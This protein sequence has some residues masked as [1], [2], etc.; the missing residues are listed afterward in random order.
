M[1]PGLFHTLLSAALLL[2]AAASAADTRTLTPRQRTGAIDVDG[3]LDEADW[4]QAPVG[5]DF[6]QTQPDE[7]KP[8]TVATRVRVL[9]DETSLY[10]G[11]ECDD[12]EEPTLLLNRRDRAVEADSISI[13][14]DS[15]LDK[16]T[17]Y[18]F[19][20]Y[21]S[22][23]QLDGL[24]FDDTGFGTEWDAAWESAVARTK[25]GWSVEM[26]IPLRALR[27][28]EKVSAMGLDV[29]RVLARRH[30][31]SHWQFVPRG[32]P[33]VV[34]R[35]GSLTGLDGMSPVRV[36]ELKPY[37]AA[38]AVLSGPKDG[39]ASAPGR[40]GG[41]SSI[42]LNTS[43]TGQTCAG[44]DFRVGL[45]SDLALLG[46]VNPDFG[47]VEADQ[48]VLNL[49]T[50]ETLFPEKRPFFVEGLDLFAPP[51]KMTDWG[52]PYGGDAFQLFYSRRVGHALFAPSLADGQSLLYQPSAR[53]V[54][55]AI[56]LVGN[57]GPVTVAMLSAI[58]PS[59][60][61]QVLQPNGAKAELPVA[62]AAHSAALRARVP[63]GG[64][65]LLGMTASG[66]DPLFAPGE[67]HAHA[68][69]LDLTAFDSERDWSLTTQLA[70]SH[71]SGGA[72]VVQPDGTVI[73]SG[74]AGYAAQARLAK[75]GGA[76]TGFVDVDL[77]SPTFE[78]N[79]LGFAKRA[80]LFRSFAAV[81]LKDLH[82]SDR[83]QKASLTLSGREIRDASLTTP[84]WR[85]LVLQPE[86]TFN[87]FWTLLGDASLILARGDDREL[88]DGTPYR[89]YGG[90]SLLA[91]ITTDTNRSFSTQIGGARNFYTRGSS[92]QG[93]WSI[94]ARPGAPVEALLELDYDAV[95]DDLRRIAPA[96]APISQQRTYL[97]APQSA[98]AFSLLLRATVAISP[99]LT[100]QAYA[101]LFTAGVSYG[102]PLKAD[103]APGK[104]VVRVQDLVPLGP[105]DTAPVNDERQ[106]GLDVNLILRWEWRLGSAL[107]L[108]YAHHAAG[109]V[110]P[111]VPSPLSVRNNLAT[112]DGAPRGDTVLVKIDLLAAR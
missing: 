60:S 34:S 104:N 58:E 112:L 10:V 95:D 90:A 70:G 72:D 6:V 71:L 22:G 18:R 107:Y 36:L 23:Q 94:T 63:L 27:L 55:T 106:A 105:T 50:F 39:P 31:E 64:N 3:K 87:N 14:I 79:D 9:W 86:I 73:S 44:L 53:P 1:Q 42:G 65:V 67:R 49:T 40:L 62:E 47:Q 16:R 12:P 84:L 80:N 78:V 93:V 54:A 68:G 69:A 110:L 11:A 13:V 8:A 97:F 92:T 57:T 17:A 111:G 91:V 24:H 66:R 37:F 81:A 19:T 29:V 88:G 38:Q 2:G 30:E 51:V 7:G 56:K 108:V 26:R 103:V 82:P 15:T 76:I 74:M 21:A 32:V 43:T 100:L 85:D 35:L 101:Q 98:Q 75:D 33:G 28:P 77:L 89:Q 102:A 61:A 83:W 46:A 48:R 59:V 96:T 45:T 41:C 109:D 5:G 4:A 25:T 52:G 99:R 20:V